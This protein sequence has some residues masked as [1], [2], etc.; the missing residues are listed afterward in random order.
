MLETRYLMLDARCRPRCSIFDIRYFML[1]ARTRPNP[2]LRP[3]ISSFEGCGLR[4]DDDENEHPKSSIEHPTS[5]IEY[6]ASTTT[7]SIQN[8]ISS[9]EDED[10]Y[11]K[12][13]IQHPTSNIEHRGRVR[14]WLPRNLR[15]LIPV[16]RR[17]IVGS[18]GPTRLHRRFQRGRQ[19]SP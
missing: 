17:S 4:E 5:N 7:T 14:C 16:G 1:D 10:E 13:N 8:Q 2:H 3:R 18:S 12:S 15:N 19:R 6:R 9:I 11:Q